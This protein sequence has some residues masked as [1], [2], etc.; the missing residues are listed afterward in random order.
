MVCV[1]RLMPDMCARFFRSGLVNLGNHYDL[2]FG[3]TPASQPSFPDRKQ[4][5]CF[6]RQ[7]PLLVQIRMSAL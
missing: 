1:F 5:T 7:P 2:W 6:H 3:I 4:L